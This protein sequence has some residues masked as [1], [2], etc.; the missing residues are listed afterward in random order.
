MEHLTVCG[1]LVL[2]QVLKQYTTHLLNLNVTLHQILLQ[3]VHV[4][5]LDLQH[6]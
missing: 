4:Q 2:H 5:T 1:A 3:T 6:T